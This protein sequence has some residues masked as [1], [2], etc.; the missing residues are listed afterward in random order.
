MNDEPKRIAIVGA[1]I[2]G[3][4]LAWKLKEQGHFVS[5]FEKR[6]QQEVGKKPCSALYS[7]R[8]KNFIPQIENCIENKIKSCFIVFPKKKIK[9]EFLPNHLVINREKLISVL[10]NLVKKSGGE[11]FFQQEIKEIPK[12]FDYI[13]ACDGAGS[14]IR[15]LLNLP[16]PKIKIGVQVFIQ[17]VNQENFVTTY[18][19]KNG[20]CWKIPRGSCSEYGIMGEQETINKEFKDFL[21]KQEI[22]NQGK[23]LSAGIPQPHF[24]FKNSGLI[25]SN[26]DNV[27]LC[28]DACGL[29]KPWSGGG[30]IW[31]LIQ[32]DILLKNF[33]NFKAYQKECSQKFG[34]F[35]FKGIIS[36]KIIYFLGNYFPSLIPSKIR[37]DNDF[38]FFIKSFFY[39][40]FQKNKEI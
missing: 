1:G 18:P 28:G 21:K 37:Y 29:T 30:I 2:I 12:N 8:I 35:I 15:R 32:A 39:S 16:N 36:K 6:Q 5:V 27:A 13:I 19:T 7:E 40:F 26:Q 34:L 17:N 25:F 31:G 33:P 9:L 3:L 22:K 14:A 24:S 20:F 11:I 23:I 38:P 4:Y 10:I